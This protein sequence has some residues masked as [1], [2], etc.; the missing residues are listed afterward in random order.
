MDNNLTNNLV[1][2]MTS[3]ENVEAILQA[4][5]LLSKAVLDQ[6][7]TDYH[8]IAHQN[9]Q[10]RRLTTVV[11]CGDGGV[12]HD[13]VPFYFASRSPMLYA[14]RNGRIDGFDGSQEDIVY[15]VS[16]IKVFI[17]NDVPFVFTDGH[18]TMAFTEFFDDAT[19][20]SQIDWHIM[21]ARNWYD[22]EEDND[23]KRRRQAEF[24]V[25][26]SC[27]LENIIGLAV[28]SDQKKEEVNNLLLK[29]NST[30]KALVRTNWYF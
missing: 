1:L 14:I 17:E 27:K 28:K 13:Y 6:E 2:H 15:W 7:N 20:L 30:L 3:I 22:T 18:G 16:K 24:L 11:P 29:N 19:H 8:S 21:E 25:H 9:I 4:G 26:Q 10:D 12:L 5:S 23:R